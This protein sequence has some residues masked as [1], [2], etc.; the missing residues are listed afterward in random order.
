MSTVPNLSQGRL[1]HCFGLYGPQATKTLKPRLEQPLRLVGPARVLLPPFLGHH[2]RR[3]GN[4]AGVE[5]PLVI[6]PPINPGHPFIVGPGASCLRTQCVVVSSSR[7][8]DDLNPSTSTATRSKRAGWPW[9]LGLG[10]VEQRLRLLDGMGKKFQRLPG[11][12]PL[13]SSEAQD[14]M[15]FQ[16]PAPTPQVLSIGSTT[17]S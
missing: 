8:K 12:P 11:V 13:P 9:A 17:P 1:V 6:V 3:Q 7:P 16:P 15:P 14:E 2:I 5:A 4:L 10:A